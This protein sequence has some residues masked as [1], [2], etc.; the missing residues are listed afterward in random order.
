MYKDLIGKIVIVIGFLK[1]I[2]KVI[3]EWFGQEKMNVVVNYYSDLFGVDEIVDIIKYSGGKVVV[4]EVDVLKEVGI[5]VFLDVVLEYFGMFDVMVNNFG[6]N[7]VEVMLYEM[8][9]EDW[10]RVIDVNVI[11][12]FMGVKV[13]FNYMMKNNIKGNVLNILSVYQ[14][15][16]CF[17]NVQYFMFKGGI[18][19]MI[20]MLVF[21]YVNKGICVN[22]IVFGIIV[23]ELNVDMKKEV[24]R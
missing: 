9:L 11:G 22:V 18:K 23:I 4:V 7:G 14:Q 21:N 2:G 10:Q 19:M 6:F 15:I 12:I 1:G 13:V 16:L 20:E 24:N 3:V 5:Q 17:V 8:S